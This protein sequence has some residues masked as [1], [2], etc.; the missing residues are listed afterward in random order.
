[1]MIAGTMLRS[2][3]DS[4]E[5]FDARTVTTAFTPTTS[6]LQ[7]VPLAVDLKTG[8]MLWLDSSSG[9]T[10][11][12]VSAA[13]DTSVGSVVY[14]EVAR[15]RLKMGELATLWAQAH[16]VDTSDDVVDR[17]AVLALLD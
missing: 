13:D 10:D 8:K 2:K 6:A 4:G 5:P 7:S 14:D 3:P 1:D 12:C 11:E 15:P 9:S 16:N 17:D